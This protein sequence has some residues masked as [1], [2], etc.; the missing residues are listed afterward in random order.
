MYG[1]GGA[2]V[3]FL[4]KK[5]N[6]NYFCIFSLYQFG[7]LIVYGSLSMILLMSLLVW[8]FA[9]FQDSWKFFR[10]AVGSRPVTWF[11][12]KVVSN[13]TCTSF[14]K[15]A[16]LFQRDQQ[17]NNNAC[18]PNTP[19]PLEK[20]DICTFRTSSA[21][22]TASGPTRAVCCCSPTTRKKGL[23]RWVL[24]RCFVPLGLNLG[25]LRIQSPADVC[26]KKWMQLLPMYY[27][28][29]ELNFLISTEAV[30]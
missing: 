18:R 22:W 28:N 16:L 14:G 9:P 7:L 29:I 19:P 1:F 25:L 3:S 4:L 20:T 24:I 11:C 8:F 2:E 5:L 15:I 13:S 6:S 17:A 27:T 26:L 21:R 30:I 23:A 10:L 12:L